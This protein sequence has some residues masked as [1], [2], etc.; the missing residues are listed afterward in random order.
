MSSDLGSDW[1]QAGSRKGGWA[2]MGCETE[3]DYF[4]WDRNE[5]KLGKL[6]VQ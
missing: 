3:L 5:V 2:R 6:V 4:S 1:G